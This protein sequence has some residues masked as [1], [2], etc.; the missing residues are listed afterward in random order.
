[1]TRVA[2]LVKTSSFHPAQWE[3]LTDSGED[4]YIRYRN[5]VLTCELGGPRGDIVATAEVDPEAHS[6]PGD[7]PTEMMVSTLRTHGILFSSD[8]AAA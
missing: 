8:A 6:H 5:H 3:G 1:M 4:V 2:S 7:M